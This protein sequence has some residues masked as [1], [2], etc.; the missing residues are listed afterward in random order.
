MVT[1]GGR[2][3]AAA[4]VSTIP[5]V[6]ATTLRQSR[7]GSG[8]R[9]HAQRPPG[10]EERVARRADREH[11]GAGR[12]GDVHAEDEDQERVDLAVELRAERRRRPRAPRDPSVDRVE[13]ERERRERHEQRDRRGLA[14]RVRDQR[15]DADGERRPREGH[16]V[17]RPQPVGAVVG[18][19]VRERE[20]S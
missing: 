20:H 16:P 19:A 13:H 15:R 10:R 5:C 18:E 6:A 11:P 1:A 8:A 3:S 2:T 7:G 14:E 4:T 12:A 17:G 9:I